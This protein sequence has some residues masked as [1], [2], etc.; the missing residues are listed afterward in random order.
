[1]GLFKSKMEKKTFN[2][3]GMTCDHCRKSVEDG[4]KM[5]EGMAS[6]KVDLKKKQARIAFDPQLLTMEKI[7]EKVEKLGY[8]ASI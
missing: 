1:M 2:V 4:L 3:E 7:G 8:S 6:V 5:M